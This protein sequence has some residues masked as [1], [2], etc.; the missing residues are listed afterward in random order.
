MQRRTF[1][2]MAA[3]ALAAPGTKPNI[4]VILG[5]DIGY[6]DLSCY[7]ATKVKTPNCDRLA[8]RGIRFTD[9]HSSAATCTPTRYS[10]MTGEYAF[11]KRGTGILPGD[12][13]LIIDPGRTTLPSVLKQAGYTTGC[14]GKWHLGLGKERPD[15]N[16]EIR[17]GPLEVGFDYA[18]IIPATGDRVPCVYVENH[19]VAGLDPKDPIRVS[20][21]E[22]VGD[23]PTG[24]ERPD[25]LR[26]K[27]S[28]GHNDTIV[29]GIGRIGFMSGGKS[30]RWVDEDIAKTITGKAV[31]FLERSHDHPF[32]LY[33]ATH[34]IHV[35]RVPNQQFRGTTGCGIRCDAVA[36]FD[37]SVGQILDTLDRLKL[38]NDTMVIVTSDN[39]PVLDNGYQDGSPEDVNGHTPAGPLRG[40]KSS[41][42]EGGTRMPFLASWPARIKPQVSDAL[43]GQ[44]DLLASF[45]S[46][47]G[48]KL[49]ADAGPDSINVLP[50]LLGE[51]E[52][53]R[54]QIVEHANMI[55]L[56]KGQ[57]KLVPAR[58][59]R[60][61]V[62]L[63]DL[64][65]DLGETQNVAGRY[66]EIAREL[67]AMLDKLR[68]SGRSRP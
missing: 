64:S 6:G 54:D 67:S 4:V 12:A 46:L 13:P 39:G 17:P 2:Q 38:T 34:D 3:A 5:D 48:Q 43:I 58:G 22:K 7:G 29:N 18:F 40:G 32:F 21:K 63:Y 60:G 27:P 23:E 14:V 49:S 50:A 16:D 61:G 42:Y 1:L 52:Q 24:R 25:L 15:W 51:S 44:M 30:A 11:R 45:A 10:L 68:D 59:A 57:W 65:K 53:G 37:W 20:Y 8:R 62:E 33:F 35:P 55:A 56:R 28:N 9:A 36:E 66:P 26:V 19:R 47:T 41:I 31:S